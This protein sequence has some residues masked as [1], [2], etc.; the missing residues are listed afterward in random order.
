MNQTNRASQAGTRSW[1]GLGWGAA[2]VLAAVAVWL[3]IRGVQWAHLRAA[4]AHPNWLLLAL[5]LVTV[6]ATTG[7]KAARWQVLLRR[8]RSRVRPGRVLRVLLIGQ[9]G[10]SFLPARMG[11]VARAVLLGPQTAEG[12]PAVLGTLVVEKALDGV[13][14]LLTL[15]GLALWTPLPGWLRQPVLGFALG[16]SILLVLL[17]LTAVRQEWAGRI[18]R[19]LIRRLPTGAQ[20]TAESWLARFGLGLGLLQEPGDALL[21]LAWSAVVWGLAALT[22]VVAL[23]ALGI[24]APGWSTWLVLVT[25]YVANFLPSVPAQVGVFE[26]ACILAL[27]A[28]SVSQEPALAFGIVLHLLVYGPPAVLGPASMIIE[29]LGWNRLKSVI[30]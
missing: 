9:M 19:P 17:T 24:S 4:L 1:R 7:A 2:L 25:G 21:A 26:Y 22:N 23:A 16:T 14:G 30:R 12:T 5:A 18:V 28:A 6:L 15:A 29:G 3:S 20:A 13:M 11:D 10:N 8:C 27:T